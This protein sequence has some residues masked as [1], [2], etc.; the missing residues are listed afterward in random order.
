MIG[1]TISQYR[2]LEELGG[3]GMGVVYKAED[4]RLR[5]FVA[6]KFLRPQMAQDSTALERFE[7]EAQAASA[8]DHP[9]IC[10]VYE[11]GEHEG[12]PFIAMQFLEGDT[13]K[14]RIATKSIKPDVQLDLAIQ[15]AD[16]LDAAHAKG[17]VHRDIKPANIFVTKSGQAKIL[18]FGLAKLAAARH[19]DAE[20]AL[21]TATAPE[22]LTSPG[23]AIGTVAYMSPEQVRGEALD[24][25][26]DLFSLGIVLYEMVTGVLPFRGNTSGVITEAIL[27][28]EPVPAVRVNPETPAEFERIIGKC[29]EKDADLR[30][31]H[32]SEI[33]S[34]VKRLKRD[35]ESG[36]RSGVAPAVELSRS[37]PSGWPR[38]AWIGGLAALVLVAIGLGWR[39]WASRDMA[40]IAEPSQRQL[41]SNPPENWVT[42]AAISPDGKYLAYT[43][44]TGLLVRAMDSGE[45][46]PIPLPTDFSRGWI[47]SM[48]WFPDG[49]RLLVGTMGHDLATWIVTVVGQAA[50]QLVR[51]NARMAALS[52]D[53]RSIAFLDGPPG[54]THSLWVS[55]LNGDAAHKLLEAPK[56]GFVGR[57]AW[58]PDGH[59][60]AYVR[61]TKP[62]TAPDP[63]LTIEVQP[64]A[65]GAPKTL[66]SR[67]R[68]PASTVVSESNEDFLYWSQDW[69][70][71]FAADDESG[72]PVR[73][74]LW[75]TPVDRTSGDPGGEPR[76][77]TSL[78]GFFGS[79]PTATADGRSL[80]FVKTAYHQDVYMGD[81]DRG[82]LTSPRRFTLDTHNS[83]PQAWTPDSRRVLFNSNR[84][85]GWEL[86]AQPLTGNLP[87][88]IV[89]S[90]AGRLGGINGVS[91]DGAWVL[92]WMEPGAHGTEP[93]STVFLMRQPIAGGPPETVLEL[94]HAE[95]QETDFF[96][97][98]KTG[99]SCVLNLWEGN[100]LVLFALD[101]LHGKGERLAAINV[102]SQQQTAWRLSPDASQ[103]AVIDIGRKGRIEIFTIAT[104]AWSEIAVEPGWGELQAFSWAPDGQ[105][106]FMTTWLPES[107][108]LIRV[109]RAG[110]VQLLLNNAHRQWMTLPMPSPDGKHLMFQAQTWDGNVWM[111]E[112]LG[113]NSHR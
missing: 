82:A 52:P 40:P 102:K 5:R 46:H 75:V 70:L 28:R 3:G 21:P 41:T 81:L 45:T 96:C 30:Y 60:I 11:I 35:T 108:N 83:T 23:S 6:L 73:E 68:L 43:D 84:N 8:L 88:R 107:F 31:Q 90:A 1:Q 110:K 57:P 98:L 71:L 69:R 17:I 55:G 34:D 91:P 89:S 72:S 50:P 56:A 9:N 49:G 33:R 25:R 15:L 59:W 4:T 14:Q 79:S 113:G 93:G 64:A 111:L 67:A 2:V 26:T 86:F 61:S 101:P 24:A 32:A 37:A 97:P 74:S 109:S 106:F 103:I 51:R 63:T 7:R 19:A 10:M 112:N 44:Q 62:D 58:S 85:G 29:L 104:R 39:A 78:A 76:L 66:V 22:F 53:G 18:D 105:G 20:T 94:R 80:A 47:D 99:A 54:D 27:N 100:D 36:R 42:D 65:G 38:R 48:V 13:L 95:A 16:A 12:Q 92:Y 77:L 87:E